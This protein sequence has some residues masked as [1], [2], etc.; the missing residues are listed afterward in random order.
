MLRSSPKKFRQQST[1]KNQR[2][3][4]NEVLPVSSQ[5]R[6][7]TTRHL[8][9]CSVCGTLLLYNLKMTSLLS[10]PELH[11]QTTAS[12]RLQ[13]QYCKPNLAPK[14]TNPKLQ[15]CFFAVNLENPVKK[16]SKDR[17]TGYRRRRR[18]VFSS[19]NIRLTVILDFE[20]LRGAIG[21][22]SRQ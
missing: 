14:L 20:F 12:S 3:H 16:S 19:S 9:L 21:Q 5:Q 8:S 18:R 13:Q 4:L 11:K 2:R 15:T 22:G 10:Y 1:T 7:L 6:L 17:I